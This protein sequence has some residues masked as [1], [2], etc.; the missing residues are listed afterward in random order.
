MIQGKPHPI[1]NSSDKIVGKGETSIILKI[2][3]RV[4]NRFR[5]NEEGRVT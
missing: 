4:V 2:G 1:E 5:R 3:K